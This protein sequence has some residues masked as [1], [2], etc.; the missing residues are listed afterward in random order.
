MWTKIKSLTSLCMHWGCITKTSLVVL[1]M[2]DV[3]ACCGDHTVK[4]TNRFYLQ[5]ARCLCVSV[6]GI[7]IK[8]ICFQG[9][10]GNVK[11]IVEY[12]ISVKF[13]RFILSL[14][15]PWSREAIFSCKVWPYDPL[16][17]YRHAALGQCSSYHAMQQL[18]SAAKVASLGHVTFYGHDDCLVH[19]IRNKLR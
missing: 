17:I 8:Q 7:Y 10:F 4:H 11:K 15:F 14:N 19:T 13:I 9:L 5:C 18:H 2:E 6:G 12:D 1:L 16:L 3:A